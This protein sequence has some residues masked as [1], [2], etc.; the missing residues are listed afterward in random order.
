[1]V[2]DQTSDF[3]KKEKGKSKEQGARSK[4]VGRGQTSVG[5][6]AKGKSKEQNRIQ[7]SGFSSKLKT[8]D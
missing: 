1:M 8:K 5:R 3:R 7:G 4:T 6:K 2:R